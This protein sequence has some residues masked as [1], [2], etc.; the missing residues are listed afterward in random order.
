MAHLSCEQ[1]EQLPELTCCRGPDE[2]SPTSPVANWFS[3]RTR[4]HKKELTCGISVTNS[5][6][7]AF[8]PYHRRQES[9]TGLE[10]KDRF[11]STPSYNR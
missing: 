9:G 3:P 5:P 7:T 1:Y 2:D 4:N 10:S 6:V 11:A 8:G